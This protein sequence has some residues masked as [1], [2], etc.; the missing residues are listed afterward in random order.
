MVAHNG[1]P[2]YSG[3]WRSEKLQLK[4]SHHKKV[5]ETFTSTNKLAWWHA[6]VVPATW[7][8]E[9]RGSGSE[10]RSRQKPKILSEKKNSSKKG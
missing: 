6:C 1:N 7:E 9:V 5:S 8:A 4:N 2:R 10:A 3:K